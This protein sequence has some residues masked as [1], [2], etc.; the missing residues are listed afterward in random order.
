MSLR[1]RRLALAVVLLAQ[2]ALFLAFMHRPIAVESD[3]VR[4]ELAA[5]N[6][7]QGRG[8][9]LP[10]DDAQDP[11]VRGWACTRHPEGCVDGN[12]PVAIYPPGYSVFVAAIYK[13]CGRS[14]VA[15]VVV[16]LLLH[17]A[18]FVM[19]ESIAARKLR[20]T[21][22]L[23]AMGIAGIYPFMAAQASRI[24]SDHLGVV[25]FMAALAA[26]ILM[27][28]GRLRGALFG[29][30]FAAA[31]LTRP[32][33]MFVFPV[34]IVWPSVW[35]AAQAPRIERIV[36]V[37]AF[38]LPFAIWSGRNAYWYGRFVPVTVNGVGLTLMHTTFEFDG[39]SYDEPET[40]YYDGI[41]AK[42]GNDGLGYA[43]SRA[44]MHDAMAKI[45]E[46]PLKFVERVLIHVPKLWISLGQTGH[47][48]NR[49]WPLFLVFLGGLWLLGLAGM[50]HKWRDASWHVLTLCVLVYWLPLLPLPGEARRTLPIRLPHLLL[51]AAFV[52]DFIDR[53]RQ[54]H[55]SVR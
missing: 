5:W 16:Q 34:L 52:G 18:L 1:L 54:K 47:G 4:Y 41:V 43:S 9:V 45:R 51:A 11:D 13:V 28:P 38:L 12:Y 3:N 22:Y 10:Y 35:R 36:A 7:A 29:L 53:R 14:L 8:L 48:V 26:H 2:G 40:R 44:L 23:F 6:L 27:H 32:Y 55:E 33:V 46:R 39:K 31:T 20:Q 17:L 42:Y 37:V 50:V 21:G 25:L 19:F 30:L 49:A 15:I 24:M